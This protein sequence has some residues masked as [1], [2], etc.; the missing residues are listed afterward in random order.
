[1]SRNVRTA[2]TRT[3]ASN[4]TVR[5]VLTY[6]VAHA[7]KDL[8]AWPTQGTLARLCGI[9]D[10]AVRNALRELEA[11]GEIRVI[12]HGQGRG[13]TVYCLDIL[14]A[15]FDVIERNRNRNK[16]SFLS[17]SKTGTGVPVSENGKPERDDRK[18]GTRIPIEETKE[19]SAPRFPTSETDGEDWIFAEKSEGSF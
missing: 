3:S 15:D 6:L 14:A 12:T 4:A 1:M 8:L 10:R 18:T 11:L 13:A 7:G 9:T 5:L 2:G 16:R 17:A 19:D